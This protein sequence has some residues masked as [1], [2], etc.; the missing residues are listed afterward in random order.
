MKTI[1]LRS[2]ICAAA[3]GAF[4]FPAVSAAPDAGTSSSVA[5][6]TPVDA[7]AAARALVARVL[8][9]HA[10]DFDF[11]LI[12]ADADRDVLEYEAGP[13]G[14]VTLRGNGALA[15]ATAFNAYLRDVAHADYDWLA[16]GPLTLDGVLPAPA[17]KVRR[18]CAAKERYFLNTCTYGYTMPFWDWKRWERFSD[19][20]AMNG[21]N[22]PLAQAGQ[23]AVWR[24]VW[25]SYGMSDVEIRAY[26]VGPAHLPWQR[27]ANIDAWGGPLPESYIDGQ[28]VLNLKLLA[29]WRELGMRPILNAFAGHVPER[30]KTLKPEAKVTR[31]AP[32]WGGMAARYATFFL[33]PTDPLFTDIQRRFIEKQTARYGTDHLYSCDPFNEMRPP[34][35]EPGYLAKVGR[36]IYESMG[37]VDADAV[38]YQMAWTFYYDKVWTAPRVKAMTEAVPK[39]RLTYIDYVCESTEL[40]KGAVAKDFF[41]APFT[42]NFL[43]N[44]GGNTYLESP[45]DRIAARIGEALKHPGCVGVGGTL[46]GVGVSPV[47]YGLLLDRPWYG[48]GFSTTDWVANY[49]DARAGRVDPAVRAAWATLHKDVLTAYSRNDGKR[50][51]ETRPGLPKAWKD[52]ITPAVRKTDAALVSALDSLFGAGPEC[53]SADAYRFDLVNFTRQAVVDSARIRHADM[54]RAYFA[55]DAAGFKKASGAFL[56]AIR[57]LDRLVATRREFLLGAWIADARRWAKDAAEAD[58]YEG[59]AR[60]IVTSWQQSGRGLNDYA[61]RQWNGLLGTFYLP[62]WEEFVRRLDADVSGGAAFDAKDYGVWVVKFTDAWKSRTS[63]KFPTTPQGDSVAVA[64]ELFEKHRATLIRRP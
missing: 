35:L 19:W 57:D 10:G 55:R 33:D 38:W 52:P 26:F 7:V 49:A 56:D 3:L 20:M 36:T 5:A 2:L 43:G 51:V 47:S 58:Y 23:E 64:K 39:G 44:F 59:D 54:M 37:A 8:P 48:D 29:R 60:E 17:A 41:G 53:A 27:M 16:A 9:A 25:R 28:A 11:A 24:D 13:S 61:S 30:L 46:E 14:R 6:A 45:L 50:I 34:S 18:V 42:W 62:R 63:D 15:L 31:I 21:V 12:P 40:Y 22:R 4:A 32:G 1:R